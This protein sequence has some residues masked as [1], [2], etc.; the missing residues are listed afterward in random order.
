MPTTRYQSPPSRKLSPS[1]LSSG[2]S[3]R[4]TESPEHGHALP[5]RDVEV[6]QEAAARELEPGGLGVGRRRAERDHGGAA[7]GRVGREIG[8]AQRRH[9]AHVGHHALQRFRRGER[10]RE[11]GLAGAKPPGA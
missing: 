2:K 5:V 4:T 8:H 9:R 6:G 3:A 1:G 10:Q 7:T 11:R